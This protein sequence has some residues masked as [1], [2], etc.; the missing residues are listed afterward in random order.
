MSV[1]FAIIVILVA[2]IATFKINR[3]TLHEAPIDVSFVSASTLH[4]QRLN[5]ETGSITMRIDSLQTR[6]IRIAEQQDAII[7]RINRLSIVD[8]SLDVRR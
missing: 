4:A 3:P 2:L 5:A 8:P 1:F 7:E 6:S